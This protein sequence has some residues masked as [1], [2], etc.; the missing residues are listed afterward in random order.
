MKMMGLANWV[1]WSAW[2]TKNLLF[3]LIAGIFMVIVLKVGFVNRH[4]FCITPCMIIGPQCVHV[5]LTRPRDGCT[6]VV[7]EE[8]NPIVPLHTSC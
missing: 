5:R 6:T 2:F 1:H 8:I 4:G 7:D 3:L